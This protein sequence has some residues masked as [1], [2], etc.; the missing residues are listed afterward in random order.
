MMLVTNSEPYI[1]VI[2]PFF[3]REDLTIQAIDSVLAQTFQNFEILLI[4]DGSNESI[5][6]IKSII[7]P[8]IKRLTQTNKGP[9]AARNLGMRNAKGKYIA[10]LDS[11]DLFLPEKL[12]FQV[13]MHENNPHIWLSHTSYHYIDTN[14]SLLKVQ[15]SGIFTGQLYPTILSSCP[16]ATPT[17]LINRA[18]VDNNIYYDEEYRISEDIIFYSKIAR[19]SEIMGIDVPLS[20]I[21]ISNYTHALNPA[22]QIIGSKNILKYLK[23]NPSGLDRKQGNQVLSKIYMHIGQNY[24]YKKEGINWFLNSMRSILYSN[25]RKE[26]F[27]KIFLHVYKRLKIKIYTYLSSKYPRIIKMYR[28]F[29]SNMANNQ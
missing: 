2:I 22:A 6:K 7:N 12:E 1:S 21:R 17:V 23:N 9:A 16:I 4:D 15:H 10:F 27:S 18:V 26:E 20:L 29:K 14:N 28:K 25:N 5:D 8:K 13:K 11:D 19:L 3:N 24:L